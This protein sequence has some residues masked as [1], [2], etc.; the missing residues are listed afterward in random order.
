MIAWLPFQIKE[1]SQTMEIEETMIKGSGKSL[2]GL[3]MLNIG[4][5]FELKVLASVNTS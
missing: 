2:D 5:N 3:K 1:G 4:S